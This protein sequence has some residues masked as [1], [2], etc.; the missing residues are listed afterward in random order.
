MGDEREY[1]LASSGFCGATP[2]VEDCF[3]GAAHGLN[4]GLIIERG[5]GSQGET[6]AKCLHAGTWQVPLL[7]SPD[8]QIGLLRTSR[9]G[10]IKDGELRSTQGRL[11]GTGSKLRY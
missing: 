4:D 10:K 8:L 5:K 11:M 7:G 9:R 3:L 1:A 6:L 2:A